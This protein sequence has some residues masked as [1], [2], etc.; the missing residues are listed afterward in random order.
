MAQGRLYWSEE[1]AG[2]KGDSN[3]AKKIVILEDN[4]ARRAAMERCLQ[5]RFYQFDVVFFEAAGPM[6]EF[7][8]RHL[9]ETILIGL[10]HDLEMQPGSH[11]RCHDMGTG[12][13]VA[14]FLAT[15]KPTCPVIIHSS[16][17]TATLGM[18][19]VLRD[20]HWETRVVLPLDDLEWIPTVW[21]RTVR[22][23]IVGPPAARRSAA[24][25]T[26]PAELR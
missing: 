21:F 1:I 7:C 16:N 14:D 18:E 5:D 22:R 24:S 4:T 26:K 9:E 17:A 25:S 2:L 11:G 12:R 19:M 13:Q 3:M 23:A 8:A 20:A 10:D 15:R 6:Q